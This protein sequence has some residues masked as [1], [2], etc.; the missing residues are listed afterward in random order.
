MWRVAK[1]SGEPAVFI[2]QHIVTQKTISCILL[3]VKYKIMWT[4]RVLAATIKTCIWFGNYLNLWSQNFIQILVNVSFLASLKYKASPLQN[5]FSELI[6]CVVTR[7][8]ASYWGMGA[9][10]P[11][12]ARYFSLLYSVW[13]FSGVQPAS[14][15]VTTSSSF[16]DSKMAGAR[17]WYLSSS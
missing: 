5:A 12:E 2:R 1:V 3:K 17:N 8:Q 15:P 13:T 14:C 16:P 6:L 4:Y 10:F 9:Q 7:L 11:A